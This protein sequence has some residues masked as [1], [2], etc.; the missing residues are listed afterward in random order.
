MALLSEGSQKNT[1]WLARYRERSRGPVPQP[2]PEAKPTTQ[3][4][5]PSTIVPAIV[6]LALCRTE[7]TG[8]VVRRTDFDGEGFR[9]V[10][11]P[12]LA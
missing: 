3:F 8:N 12:A 1:D 11:V 2:P 6:H 5:D 10:A 9:V 7:F 4:S